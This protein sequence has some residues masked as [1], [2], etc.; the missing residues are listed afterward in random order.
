MGF[1]FEK[2]LNM[3]KKTTKRTVLVGNENAASG[4][5]KKNSLFKKN[6]RNFRIGGDIQPKRYLTR[7]VRWPKYIRIQRQKRIL[8]QRLKVPPTIAQFNSTIE[9]DQASKLLKLLAKYSPETRAQ[10]KDRL[11]TA[12]A[13]KTA[14]KGAK[15]VHIKF[16]LN[17]I[18][19]LVEDKK[20]KLVVI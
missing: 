13:D 14:E 7:F 4:S 19:K 10:K 16:G 17:H 3:V 6:P 20:A 5:G 11:A 15:P 12:A 18:T 2:I 8:M 9:R 1:Y